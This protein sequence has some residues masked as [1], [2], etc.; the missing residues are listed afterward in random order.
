M[1]GPETIFETSALCHIVSP[2]FC[3]A[4]S[5]ISSTLASRASPVSF[6][7]KK[8]L[9]GRSSQF[10]RFEMDMLNVHQH[11]NAFD[12][13]SFLPGLQKCEEIKQETCYNMPQVLNT[14]GF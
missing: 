14:A 5:E 4:D 12:A 13:S 10:A 11:K 9:F 6:G 7:K 1:N 3:F 8:Q 2:C